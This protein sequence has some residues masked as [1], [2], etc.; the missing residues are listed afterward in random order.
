MRNVV[1]STITSLDAY[2][3]GPG[4]DVLALPFDEGFSA[5]NLERLQH[6]DTLLLG[7]R[8]FEGFQSYWPPVADDE[9]QPPVER[10]ISER[11]NAIEKVVISDTLKLEAEAPWRA[12]TRVVERA[13]A[14]AV[15][16]DLK[17]GDGGDILVFGSATMWNDLLR[18][19][20]VDELHVMVGPALIGGGTPVYTGPSRVPLQLLETRRLDGSQL[21]LIRYTTAM[22]MKG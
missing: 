17:R 1:V 13:D 16:A 15:V 2:H 4:Q 11:N 3:E 9:T 14:A 18:A 21:V 12:T 22:G 20:L 7:R 19:G 6:A 10:A 5:Y 8:S